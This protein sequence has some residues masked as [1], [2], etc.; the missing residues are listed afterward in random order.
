[1]QYELFSQSLHPIN[2]QLLAS[3]ADLEIKANLSTCSCHLILMNL[4]FGV[5]DNIPACF[6]RRLA[7]PHAAPPLMK[8]RIKHQI[9]YQ[10][11]L[12]LIYSIK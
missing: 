7:P 8:T 5:G 9:F 1:M 6:L 3:S 2:S 11:P 4:A 10:T 12:G